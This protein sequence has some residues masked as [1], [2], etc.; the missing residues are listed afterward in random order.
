MQSAKPRIAVLYGGVSNEHEISCLSAR[1]VIAAIDSQNYEVLQIGI[2]KS[3]AWY[4][5]PDILKGI[6]DEALPSV[7]PIGTPV[8]LS[9]NR[10]HNGLVALDGSNIV[11]N[12]DAVFPVLHGRYGED[13]TIQGALEFAG[14]P[15]VGAGSLASALAMDKSQFKA[16]MKACDILT[17]AGVS[18]TKNLWETNQKECLAKI[19]QLTFPVFVKPARAGSSVGVSKAND[20][21]TLIKAIELA[22]KTDDIIVI[23]QAVGNPR[24]IECGVIVQR[25]VA[26]V[27]VPSEIKVKSGY[28]FYSYEAKYVDDSTDLIVP[29]QLEPEVAEKIQALA[30]KTFEAIGA[31]GYARVDFLISDDGTIYVNELNTIPGFTNISMFPRMFVATGISYNELVDVLIHDALTRH[32]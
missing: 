16:I 25:G 23:E 13:G 21:L 18:I 2:T 11:T 24:E 27:S 32:G 28:D 30:L 19:L 29:A 6:S 12:L 3:G 20:E 1:N 22:S 31:T 4:L 14:I 15:C 5:Q 9:L 8:T 26:K 10:E 7:L 17:V